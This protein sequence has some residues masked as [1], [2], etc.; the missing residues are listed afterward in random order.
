MS[1]S[2]AERLIPVP[3]VRNLRDAG[4]FLTE[5]GARVAE[6][7]LYR[8]GSLHELTPEGAQR[9]AQL[10]LRTVIDLRSAPELEVWPDHRLDGEV[11]FLH[12]PT[13]PPRERADADAA[14]A[15]AEAEAAAE[16]AKER[17]AEAG[18]ETLED[19]YAFMS[20]T[21]GPAIAATVSALAA[22]GAL[23]ALVHCAVGKDRTGV[24]VATLLS[25]LGVADADIV[26]DYH[27][28][29]TGLG[30]DL[31]PVYYVDEHGNERRS[32]PVHEGLITTF[33][34]SLRAT[35]GNASQ[36]LLAHGVKA[37]ELEALHAAFL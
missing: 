25:A 9:L 12:L 14:D 7:L 34:A 24:T 31:G 13:F 10:G 4:G 8:A 33:L 15:E 36:Y 18:E 6:S 17:D 19:L 16:A 21:A 30:L 22:P 28:S 1:I 2:G 5:G 35:H 32:R 20:A 3:G 29:N 26:A 23:P 37:G 27:L 11:V